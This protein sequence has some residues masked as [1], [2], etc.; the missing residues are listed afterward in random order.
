MKLSVALLLLPVT[1]D[2][3]VTSHMVNTCPAWGKKNYEIKKTFFLKSASTLCKKRKLLR[4]C[5][6]AERNSY[7]NVY[8]IRNPLKCKVV[9]KVKLV[10]Q[11]ALHEVYNL[12]IDHGG[13]FKYLE[14][15]SCGVIPYYEEVAQEEDRNTSQDRGKKRGRKCARL[16]SISSSNSDNLSIAIR[17][18]TYEE[19]KN[20]HLHLQYGYCSGYIKGLKKNDNIYLTGAHGSFLL[21]NNVLEENRNLILI[22][23]GTGISPYI[24]FLKKIWGIQ[25]GTL[26]QNK[27]TYNGKIYL[28]YGVYNEDSIL[29]IQDL[30]HFAKMHPDNFHVEYVFSSMK[31]SD[32]SSH[33]VQDEI[34]R[35]RENFLRLFNELKCELYICGHKSIRGTIIDILKGEDQVLAAEKRKRVHVEVY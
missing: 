16:Y 34:Y 7:T 18:H 30:E 20:G 4:R 6:N 13:M 2:G 32:V 12:E 24:A 8:T 26:P 21:P 29:Y 28:Y 5:T 27:S 1:I 11:N 17:I 9:D 15:H 14:G 10:R 35:R 31:N 25:Q 3:G 23:T 33:H 22:A 19:E